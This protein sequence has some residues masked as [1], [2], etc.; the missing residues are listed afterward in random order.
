MNTP[1]PLP[2]GTP[3]G[4]G[5]VKCKLIQFNVYHHGLLENNATQATQ[6]LFFTV[7]LG[8]YFTALQTYEYFEAP[9]TFADLAYGSTF[10]MAT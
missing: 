8:L 5:I 10:F 2:L 1:K 7:L 6:G 3:L 4:G 9:L